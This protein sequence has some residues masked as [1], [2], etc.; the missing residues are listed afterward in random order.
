MWNVAAFALMAV[1]VGGTLACNRATTAQGEKPTGVA[2]AGDTAAKAP[3]APEIDP[4]EFAKLTSKGLAVVDLKA[5]WCPACNALAPTVDR[6]A[7]EYRGRIFI[8]KLDIDT[9]G[10]REI[11]GRFSV[12]GIPTLIFLRDGVETERMVGFKEEPV[13]RAAI[14]RLLE[15]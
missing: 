9:P 10:A 13:I 12:T 4:A 11:A 2:V 5:V 6:L 8:G 1:A 15:K 3:V 14:G 7:A